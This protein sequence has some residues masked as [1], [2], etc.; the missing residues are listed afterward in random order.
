MNN[1]FIAKFC[2][3]YLNLPKSHNYSLLT[4]NY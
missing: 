3:E 2:N 1:F 4:I